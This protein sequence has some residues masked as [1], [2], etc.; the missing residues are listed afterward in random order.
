MSVGT[1]ITILFS[2]F[3]SFDDY[4]T[5]CFFLP[6]TLLSTLSNNV[7]PFDNLQYCKKYNKKG[8]KKRYYIT[9]KIC[10]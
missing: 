7:H 9:Y 10:H 5:P 1:L 4:N 2:Q 6:S 3:T 8:N